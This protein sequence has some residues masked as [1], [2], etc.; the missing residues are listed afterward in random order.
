[1]AIAQQARRQERLATVAPRK[2]NFGRRK[3]PACGGVMTQ[4]EHWGLTGAAW[5]CQKCITSIAA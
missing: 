1:M 2:R 5:V 3:C 4:R